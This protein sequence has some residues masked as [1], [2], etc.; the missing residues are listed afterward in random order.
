MQIQSKPLRYEVWDVFTAKQFGGNPLAVFFD[1]DRLTDAQRFGLTREM[2]HSETTF[3]TSDLKV[4]IFT[5]TQELPFAGHPVLGTAFAL[6]RHKP[7]KT[8]HVVVPQG[9]IP[10]T[11]DGNRAM[12]LQQKPEFREHHEASILAPL[13][14]LKPEDL[15]PNLPIQNVSTGRP[16]LIVVLKSME[17]IQAAKCNWPALQEYLAKGDVQR[18]IYLL[19]PQTIDPSSQLHARKFTPHLEDPATGSAAGC[20]AAYAVK[21]GLVAAEKIARIE[22]GHFMNRPSEILIAASSNLEHVQVGGS[23][24]LVLSGEARI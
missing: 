10:V 12:M 2:N 11:F 1:T 9:S 3:V 20:A 15:M 14:G 17:S 16:N 4:R 23:S 6:Q 7:A 22:Q 5:A 21:Y 13:L 18:G 8:I 19:T 24:V